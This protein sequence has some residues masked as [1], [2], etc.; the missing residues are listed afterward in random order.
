MLYKIAHLLI[1]E[2]PFEANDGD[3]YGD[4]NTTNAKDTVMAYGI[5]TGTY[6]LWYQD[7]VI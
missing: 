2:H 5:K 3:V 4:V 1:L 7:I 6:P